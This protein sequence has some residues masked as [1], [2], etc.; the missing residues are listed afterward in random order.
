MLPPLSLSPFLQLRRLHHLPTNL[1]TF[2]H[3]LHHPISHSILILHI[4]NPNS[5]KKSWDSINLILVLIAL[6]FGFLA[7]N[8]NDDEKL[9]F[10]NGFDRSLPELP[11]GAPV[12]SPASLDHRQWGDFH[13]QEMNWSTGLRR[14]RTRETIVWPEME[15]ISVSTGSYCHQRWR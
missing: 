4:F 2:I 14:Q 5:L 10:E 8:I 7:R 3:S 11:T 6:A 12:M 9:S 15:L 13:D 1:H